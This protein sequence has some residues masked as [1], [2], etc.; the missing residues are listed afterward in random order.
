MRITE[1]NDIISSKENAVILVVGKNSLLGNFAI[2]NG[3]RLSKRLNANTTV[4]DVLEIDSELFD[5]PLPS[6]L[7]YRNNRLV[8]RLLGFHS[9]NYYF[10]WICM[11]M[12]K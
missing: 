4:Y 7:L 11:N 5:E 9:S 12:L 2:A 10:D 3:K 6:L 1:L 8:S